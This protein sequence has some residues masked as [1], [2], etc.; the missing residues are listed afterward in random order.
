MGQ[1]HPPFV[2]VIVPHYNSIDYLRQCLDKLSQQTWPRA[3]FE[4]VVADNNS[5]PGIAAELR[6]LPEFGSCMRPSQERGQHE[7]WGPPRLGGSYLPF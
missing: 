6:S 2:S 7:T 3:Q 5:A 4:I 1:C